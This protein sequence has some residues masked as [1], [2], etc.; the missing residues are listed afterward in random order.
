MATGCQCLLLKKR[1]GVIVVG[2]FLDA[3]A[4]R[5]GFEH[6]NVARRSLAF[7]SLSA[8]HIG[9]VI[10]TGGMIECNL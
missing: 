4:E 6:G 10:V 2:A 7:G 3:V 1:G 9:F 8:T 5:D